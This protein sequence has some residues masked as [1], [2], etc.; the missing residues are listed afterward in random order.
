MSLIT[1]MDDIITHIKNLE[2]KIKKLQ[3]ENEE[4]KQENK[5]FI[6]ECVSRKFLCEHFE[7][8]NYSHYEEL[9]VVKQKNNILTEEN[10]KLKKKLDDYA[11]A[12][13]DPDEV[14]NDDN[15]S[16]SEYDDVCDAYVVEEQ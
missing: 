5:K 4:L 14:I 16:D 15:S 3:E 11:F 9:E 7:R 2:M 10:D 1:G 12:F 6:S 13:G 8:L